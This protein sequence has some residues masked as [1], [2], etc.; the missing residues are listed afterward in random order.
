MNWYFVSSLGKRA[1]ARV[2]MLLVIAAPTA[3]AQEPPYP[4]RTITVLYPYAISAAWD[5]M[6]RAIMSGISE[7]V[8]QP[9]VFESRPGAGGAVGLGATARSKPDGYTL[10]ITN[11]A[12]VVILPTIQKG[13]PYDPLRDFTAV[14]MI[15]RG[16]SFIIAGPA[17]KEKTFAEVIEAAKRAPESI[18]YAV[19]GSAHKLG[20][21]RIEA[22]TGAKFLQV[23]YAGTVQAE[24]ALLGGHV[25]ISSNSGEPEV[26]EK[27]GRVRLLASTSP[28]RNPKVPNLPSVAEF[29]PGF[30]SRVWHGFLAPA[31]LP[32]DRAEL[33]YRSIKATMQT[34]T[35]RAMMD[36]AGL[37]PADEAPVPFAA[38]IRSEINSNAELVKKFNIQ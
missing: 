22:A 31:G 2:A 25:H 12:P 30:D 18:S 8:G 34:P 15:G 24:T 35:I 6:Y 3:G 14:A 19:L 7:R 16:E 26:L 23:P 27:G 10:V 36:K 21:A 32:S 17:L 38:L 29:V 33:L 1:F 20:L 13:L 9:V 11:G 4:A 37:V 28:Q 5:P